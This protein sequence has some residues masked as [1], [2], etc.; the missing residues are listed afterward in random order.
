MRQG[1]VIDPTDVRQL[2]FFAGFS[3]RDLGRLLG[4][5]RT[6]SFMPGEAIVT[7]GDRGCTFYIVTSGEAQV[8]VG[9]RYHRLRGGDVLG[10]MAA[11]SSRPRMATVTAVESLEAVEIDCGGDPQAFL[12]DNP[13]LAV[14]LLT[15][16][17]ER[18]R[19]VEDRLDSWMGAYRP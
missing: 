13:A 9:G 1:I 17:V 15:I 2:T 16:L 10:E 4:Q 7:P 6:V 19:E 18:L 12:T 3:D 8:D 5:A 11:L 14:R